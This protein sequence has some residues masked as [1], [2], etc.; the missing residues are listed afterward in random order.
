LRVVCGTELEDVSLEN[1]DE[2]S[3]IIHGRSTCRGRWL[4]RK[5]NSRLLWPYAFIKH[6][7]VAAKQQLSKRFCCQLVHHRLPSKKMRKEAAK[8]KG[9]CRPAKLWQQWL[10]D[11][12]VDERLGSPAT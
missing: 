9:C 6:S 7:E 3:E 4:P 5:L 1:D 12:G 11:K 10:C 8:V 2:Y